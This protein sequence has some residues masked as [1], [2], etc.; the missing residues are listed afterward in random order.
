MSGEV[1]M[2]QASCIGIHTDLFYLDQTALWKQAVEIKFVRKICFNCPVRRKCLELGMQEEYGIW[3]GL[4]EKERG[5]I[6]K[7]K[8]D[9]PILK[10]LKD[11]LEVF[12]LTLAEA[13]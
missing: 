13:I 6:K 7:A 8:Y 5:L 2:K 3:G 11:D 12:G 1:D 9:S 10:T 4:T